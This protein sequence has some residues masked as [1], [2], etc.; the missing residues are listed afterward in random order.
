MPELLAKRSH[1]V[2]VTCLGAAVDTRPSP[3]STLWGPRQDSL[4][5]LPIFSLFILL[6]LLH[7]DLLSTSLPNL[8]LP[9]FLPPHLSFFLTLRL[10]FR[11]L[12]L[13]TEMRLFAPVQ[14][15]HSTSQVQRSVLHRPSGLHKKPSPL[16]LSSSLFFSFVPVCFPKLHVHPLSHRQPTSPLPH[17]SVSFLVLHSYYTDSDMYT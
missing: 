4:L 3:P 9:L 15:T 14:T 12:L 17:F 5:L 6:V 2:C 1:K 10:I 11:L 8:C 16:L 7:F 13:N